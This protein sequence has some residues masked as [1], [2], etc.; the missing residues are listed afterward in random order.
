MSQPPSRN[1]ID[2][3]TPSPPPAESQDEADTTR[4]SSHAAESADFITAR[5]SATASS[6]INIDATNPTAA[7]DRRRPHLQHATAQSPP[8][9]AASLP[10]I[11]N[12]ASGPLE[13]PTHADLEVMNGL[14][15]VR[16]QHVETVD[17][18]QVPNL[19]VMPGTEGT[20][21]ANARDHDPA[22]FA[23]V[24]PEWLD[25]P[26][27]PAGMWGIWEEDSVSEE[28]SS[29][30]DGRGG[31]DGDERQVRRSVTRMSGN[32]D[33][34]EDLLG[35]PGPSV[36]AQEEDVRMDVREHTG[37]QGSGDVQ[38]ENGGGFL[39]GGLGEAEHQHERGVLQQRQPPQPATQ[40]AVST[41]VPTP[42]QRQRQQ[43]QRQRQRQTQQHPQPDH[44][45]PLVS[46]AQRDPPAP[47]LE[48]R[49]IVAQRTRIDV[50]TDLIQAELRSHITLIH[51]ILN[52]DPN[53]RN[54]PFNARSDRQLAIWL[55]QVRLF[56]ETFTTTRIPNF[57]ATLAARGEAL[58]PQA[59]NRQ[60]Q[61]FDMV[62]RRVNGLV[63]RFDMGSEA[64]LVALRR[65]VLESQLLTLRAWSDMWRARGRERRMSGAS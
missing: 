26:W 41:L 29:D 32:G 60:R 3:T 52:N 4:S 19:Y 6:N 64:Q 42:L 58:H 57:E 48:N 33:G 11:P 8:L 53:W 22:P 44:Q 47:A 59:L 1:V 61:L 55:N 65:F 18:Q 38:S 51:A 23:I 17:L 7:P 24:N 54:Q 50:L 16:F 20:V 5:R 63:D 25:E 40:A 35:N 45:P 31:E 56:E 62:L 28:S 15:H 46:S 27:I 37:R 21:M 36:V 13:I 49:Q 30:D 2:L 43:E 34:E 14:G 12:L 9:T 39:P 10:Q